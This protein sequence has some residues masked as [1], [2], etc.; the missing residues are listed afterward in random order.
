MTLPKNVFNREVPTRNLVTTI[1]GVILA[2]VTV[3]I[4][5]GVITTEQGASL[6]EQ[7]GIITIAVTQ[8]ISAVSA[9][10]LVFKA[11]D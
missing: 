1:S 11:K 3:L 2:V 7:L 10:I 9:L 6:Q 5:V 4:L 8:F